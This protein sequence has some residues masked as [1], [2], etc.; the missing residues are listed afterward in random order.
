MGA[1]I[2][3][4][5]LDQWALETNG[6]TRYAHVLNPSFKADTQGAMIGWVYLPALFGVNR[7]DCIWGYGPDETN[8]SHLR[9][10]QNRSASTSN[11]NRW[12]L[13]TKAT[14]G[15]TLNS[16]VSSVALTAPKWYCVVLQSDGS[17]TSLYVDNVL[18]AIPATSGSN[19]GLWFGG[20]S[21]TNHTLCFGA[22]W[23][24]GAFSNPWA[25]RV[26]EF[27][28]VNRPLTTGE[29][30]ALYNAGTPRNPHRLAL[31]SD[32]KSWWRFGDSRD[33]SGTVYDEIG[34]NNLTLVGSPSYV[35]P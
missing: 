28:Y 18:Q 32:L 3:S 11:Q 4:K 17:T 8:S 9:F 31:G 12:Q 23:L 33:T 10:R 22:A 26:N 24:N 35:A 16:L 6:S 7:Q 34:T 2:G 27:A 13:L 30:T 25:G 19:N 20:V 29:I 1:L 5:M 21:G 14:D 15:G